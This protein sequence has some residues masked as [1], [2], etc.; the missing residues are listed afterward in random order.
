MNNKNSSSRKN[1]LNELKLSFMK[2]KDTHKYIKALSNEGEKIIGSGQWLLD[3]IY[4]IEKEYKTIKKNM[5]KEYFENLKEVTLNN[6][7]SPRVFFLAKNML[8]ESKG[9]VTE[10][11]CIKFILKNNK[12]LTMGELWA[13]P[14]M[15][16]ASIIINL[17]NITENLKEIH[18]DKLNAKRLAY[19]IISEKEIS[20]DYFE[21]IN[22]SSLNFNKELYKVLKD[23]SY[24]NESLYKTL[25]LKL[26]EYYVD[27]NIIMN[28]LLEASLEEGVSS[29][30]NSIREIDCI[31]WKRF[32]EET[33]MVEKIL[34]EDS[35]NIYNNM[36]F[37]SKDYYR[38]KIEKIARNNNID[39]ILVAEKLVFLAKRAK[40]SGK[41]NFRRHVGYYLIDDGVKYLNETL[42]IKNKINNRLNF[43]KFFLINILGTLFLILAT[44]F[45][46]NLLGANY[47][48]RQYI[49]AAIILLIPASEV[50]VTLIN[51]VVSKKVDIRH[52][53]KLEL[54]NI[55]K[56]QK[57]IVIVPTIVDSKKDIKRLLEKLEIAYLANKEDNLYF[58]ILADFKDSKT[59]SNDYE[60][61]INLKGINDIK[62]LNIK[63]CRGDEDDKFF[64]FNRE[65]IY[66]SHEGVFMGRER[67]RGKIIEFITLLKGGKNHTYNVISSNIDCIR[68]AK[69]IVTL[70]TDTF[71]TRGVIKKLIGAMSHPLNQPICKENIVKRGYTIMQ[72]KVSISLESKN[73]S[74]F[75]KIFGGDSGVDGYSTA[76]S[77][78]YQDLFGEGSFTGKGIIDINVFYN[79]LKDEI[80]ENRVLSH[81]LL[82]G[83][84]V[85]SAL[86]TDCEFIDN[87]PSTYIG[88]AKR[89]H[90]W[91]RGDWQLISWI[92]SKKLSAL[93]KWKIF[94]NLR[95]SLLAPSILIGIIIT[96]LS[97]NRGVEITI[98]FFLA[99][100]T[101]LLFTVTDFVVTPKNKLIGTLKS[102]KEVILIISFIPYQTYI[103]LGAIFTALFRLFISKNNLLE[104]QTA[105]EAENTVKDSIGYYYSKMWFCVLAGGLF[106]VFGFNS[107]FTLGGLMT[108]IAILWL[109]TPLI[110]FKIS[111]TIE[112]E[113][114][115]LTRGEKNYLRCISR[116]IW[117]YYEDFVNEENNYL[118]PDN[119]Q[120]K[121]Y[122]GVA[123]RTSPTNIGMGLISNI[124]A[125]DLGY[126]SLGEV[127]DRLE[128]IINGMN[129]LTKYNG[130][131]FNWYDTKTCMPLW[132]RYISTVDSGNLLG[133]LLVIKETLLEY[134]NNPLIRKEEV[135]SLIDT[136][137]ILGLDYSNNFKKVKNL[138][139]EDYTKILEEQLRYIELVKEE[140]INRED[141][142]KYWL[143]KVEKEIKNKIKYSDYIYEGVNKVL[144]EYLKKKSPSLLE[145]KKEIRSI[146]SASGEDFKEILEEKIKSLEA[147]EKRIDDLI[148]NIDIIANEMDFKILYSKDRGLFSIGYNIEEDSLGN[149]YYDLLASESRIASFL[150]IARNEVETSHWFN[151]GRAMTNAY[152]GESLVSW[153][154]TMFEY[155][156]P[157]LIM[158]SFNET[159]LDQTYKSVIKAQMLFAKKN[160]V[161]WGISES[162][163]YKFDIGEVYQYKA[164]GI[165]GIGLKR[166]LEDDLVI[167]P[168]ST[169]M[170]LPWIKNE[171]IE[172]LKRLEDLGAVGRYGFIESVDFTGRRDNKIKD[173]TYKG[174]KV[175]CYMVHH[176]GMS[177]LALDNILNN[178]I[179]QERFHNIKEVKATEILLKEKIPKYI[180]FERS[181]DMALHREELDL[182]QFITRRF[183]SSIKK[184]TE[185]LLLS[186]GNFSS[187]VTLQGSGYS[188]EGDSLLYRWKGDST[189]DNSGLFFYIKNLNSNDYWSATFEPCRKE[190]EETEIEFSVD[191][192]RFVKKCGSIKS[193][194]EISISTEENI[195][196][197]KLKLKNVGEKGRSIEVTSYM[198]VTLTTME[199]DTAHP[200]FS[201]LF[202]QTE[203]DEDTKTV[204]G[205]RRARVKNGKVPYI[206]HKPISDEEFEGIMSY[207]TSRMNFIGRDRDLSSPLALDNDSS[208]KNTVG[209]VLDPIISTRVRLRLEPNEEKVVYFITGT[210]SERDE[211]IKLSK[212]YSNV[213]KLENEFKT[214]RR[215]MQIELKNFGITSSQA[216]IYQSL[217]SYILFLNDGRKDRESY[218]RNINKHQK[219]LW[220]FGISGDIK[221]IMLVV[222]NDEDIDIVRAMIKMHIYFKNRGL[223]VDLVIYN[224]EE[225]SYEMP[226]QKDILEEVNVLSGEES[227]NKQGGIYLHNKSTMNEEIR[228]FL[229]GISAI[230]IDSSKGT[231]LTQLKEQE[232]SKY[233]NEEDILKN[234]VE[235][236]YKK[237]IE[238]E[239]KIN[240]YNELKNELDFFNGYGGF[241]KKDK[242]YV[243]VLKDNNNTPAP[244]INVISNENFGFHTSEVGS[245]HT[246]CENSRENKI[247]PW[248]NDI[249]QDSLG[250]AIYVRDNNDFNYFSITPEPVR[251]NGEYI[252]KHS[253]GYSSY[254]HIVNNIKS[255][256]IAFSPNK[257]KLK[258]QKIIL[259]NIGDKDKHLSIYYY[260]Q[261]VLGVLNY[262]TARYITTYNKDKYIYGQNPYSEYFG[263]LKAYSTIL[264][265]EN[266]SFTC[267]RREFIGVSGS[268]ESP[269][270]LEEENLSGTVGSVFDPCLV[271]KCDISLKPGEK[272]EIIVLLGE[273]ETEEQIEKSIQKY[274]NIENVDAELNNIKK[275]WVDFL[276][277]IEV[278]TKDKSMDY[279]L[280]G[281]LLYQNYSCRYLA[282]TAFYQSGGAYGFRD[283]LQDS[284]S[285]GLIN[286]S[287]TKDQII[288]S[289]SRQYLEGDVQHWWHPIINSGIRTRF[290][291]D[292]LWLPFVT[293]EYISF[294]G[295]Y[296][297]LNELAPYLEDEPL[298]EGE[299]ERYTIVNQSTKEGT[300]Y[301]H[302]IKAIEKS[303]KFG[304]HNIPLMGSGDWNDGMS[305][306]GNE[307]KGESVWLGWFLYKILVSFDDICNQMNDS[308]K[309]NRYKE[310]R[311]FIK[312][313]LE[314]NAWDGGWYRRAYFDDGTPLG[315]RENGECQ[316]D[317]LAQS[318]SV[319][320]EGGKLQRAKEAMEAVDKNLVDEDLALIKL[321][322]P[323]FEKSKEEPGYIKGYVAGVRENGG[324]YTHAATWVILALTK[325]GMGDKAFKY[326]NMINPINHGLTELDCRR[327]KLEPYVMAADV[328]VREPHGGRGG[329]SWYTGTAGWMYK[330]GLE[331][332]LGF[333]IYKGEGYKISPCIPKDWDEFEI[334]INNKSEKYNIKVKK[335]LENKIMINGKEIKGD[336]IPKDLGDANIEVYYKENIN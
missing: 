127:I 93:S 62:K 134:K 51:L 1:V 271:T 171:G 256:M 208:L 121:P 245:M 202:I 257:E 116:R 263:K 216:N 264:G 246:W 72:P 88:S 328:Y 28:T 232:S 82:E 288:R 100:A 258:I 143:N 65:K 238:N 180:T 137:N 120:E 106:I 86:V 59:E 175:R 95:R 178:N 79:V 170:V 273:E 8:S 259:E 206:F 147:F 286:P 70:D 247:T 98:L 226:L 169:L 304:E 285:I 148:K 111:T 213:K 112:E 57:T 2:I 118:A 193:E 250:E 188:K 123:N 301:E 194:L 239:N 64:F 60:N 327:Y 215:A 136:Y 45:I 10:E 265:G 13:F 94:D 7:K 122:K 267:N 228:D 310:M 219:D 227:L 291:D 54:N 269:N 33:S 75:A 221:I 332:I 47:S 25:K 177:L 42:G 49:L 235:K 4:L 311:E 253:F 268:L 97:L 277:N 325:L 251:N 163:Y 284:M 44:L 152:R 183:N 66:N 108:I 167:S 262:Q 151:L 161:P 173:Y 61:E 322:A 117:A 212:E 282:R 335:A 89:L 297:I 281:W 324:Q 199:A 9:K 146:A 333:K 35:D 261:L 266:R 182:E 24:E 12:K 129:K 31:N 233:I 74:Q 317:S 299:D 105:E 11:G 186:N 125:Y 21:I 191:K 316:I 205:K 295:D 85:R 331:N 154:G 67:K 164:F 109:F 270:G 41:Y 254:K 68:D 329:W 40:E 302:C 128:L 279:L 153:S 150:A 214:Y 218:I 336:I 243:I 308:E 234:K 101:P 207:E 210:A 99:I 184:N 26:N 334:K 27:E 156:M 326:F 162:A 15:L 84:Y 110:A 119:Y 22:K 275:Y 107:S 198:E 200:S 29:L 190:C 144:I 58:A 244:W 23:N 130:H 135:L 293:A 192:A 114:E 196:I 5:P 165:P 176:L 83:C 241:D 140:N 138:K 20:D 289:A 203:F 209:T 320:S 307:G 50:I 46:G 80:P 185:V 43:K 77:D 249:V 323:P 166:G 230:Y 223:K 92:F 139:G 330:V 197:R 32:F 155:F 229:I 211:V 76:Y 204:I 48:L 168:Y 298:K 16:R 96:L 56:E 236:K 126:I 149:S 53:P 296:S 113:K 300:V 124:T 276:G 309:A 63:Y 287:I 272:K 102:F 290:S 222:N 37:E 160:N 52:V 87:Y 159:L 131:Y 294:T 90:R 283:Q 81:D 132:P 55:S 3:N 34:M 115:E 195:D 237:I 252:I 321:L 174:K 91:V 142:F 179:L 280:N 14:L 318:W 104:W 78:T 145:L 158:K 278:R 225:S 39:E 242:S 141:E 312:E 19:K 133:Y 217:A 38:H 274:E 201:N 292:L 303:L 255:E 18:T 17:S 248:N 231:I 220:A 189:I 313:N 30:I 73:T 187:M 172:N 36:D 319:I 260:A 240:K 224:N 69:Y 315:S 314:K 157:N 305:T 103:M 181:E 71:L 306:V 6:E